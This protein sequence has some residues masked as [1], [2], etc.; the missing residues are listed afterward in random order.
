MV[1]G[2]HPTEMSGKM[3]KILQPAVS[4]MNRLKYP[5]KFALISS[6]FI[7]PWSITSYFL[8]A[9]IQKQSDFSEKELLGNE[10]LR[11][12]RQLSEKVSQLQVKNSSPRNVNPNEIK[13][14]KS[15]MVSNFQ[16]LEAVDNKLG[17]ILNTNGKYK[18]L[19][20]NFD[21]FQKNYASWN[22]NEKNEEYNLLRR[23][24]NDLWAHV[25]NTS[26]LVLDP[27]LDTYYLMYTTLMQLPEVQNHLVDVK[28]F[29]QKVSKGERLTL[30]EIV[31][32][33]RYL[34]DLEEEGKEKISNHLQ[35]AFNNNPTGNLRPTLQKS[36]E[37]FYQELDKL[38]DFAISL[39]TINNKENADALL[40]DM[41]IILKKSFALWDKAIEQQDILIQR[42][43]DGFTTKQTFL[44]LLYFI[45]LAIATYIFVGFYRGVINTVWSLDAASKLMIEGSMTEEIILDNRDE[46]AEVVKSF[47]NIA[48]ALVKSST[49][50][51]SLNE[52][53]NL[54]NIRM[55]HELDLTREVQQKILPKES[56]LAEIKDLD[57]SGFM[58]PASEVGGDYYDILH[59]DGKVKIGIGDVTGHGLES[60]M[61]ML[62]VQTAIRTLLENN[63]TNPVKFLNT[64]NRTIY[65]NVQRMQSDKNMT[66][67]LLDYENGKV[68]VSGQHEEMLVIR[69]GGMVQRLD[70]TDLGFPIGLEEEISEFLGYA[71]VQLYPGEVVV[72]YTDGITEAENSDGEQYGIKRLTQ[73]VKD[74]WEKSASEIKQ[75]VI[76]DLWEFIGAAQ[77]LDDI[78]LVILKRVKS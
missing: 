5:Q 67:C 3:K 29:A 1:G 13:A 39:V 46:M 31:S 32:L 53:L 43:V 33:L 68:R 75:S 74:N 48:G 58:Q 17:T 57:I 23:Q 60:G 20:E 25:G 52:R 14:L 6:I 27:D 28:L 12:L 22:Q 64:L 21:R 7:L 8:F 19:K 61:L 30:E 62:M 36:A 42:R 78:T 10:Y 4:L 35:A 54:E 51:K 73:V 2:A 63:E 66:L 65:N 76:D 41:D 18:A 9:E 15:E 59:Q 11:P 69:R 49:E 50:V 16:S 45:T 26:N 55:K 70:T 40:Q 77:L 71:D 56:E 47:N 37:E 34:S 24:I 72:L 44:L 38:N